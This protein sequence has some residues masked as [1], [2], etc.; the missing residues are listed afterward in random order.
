MIYSLDNENVLFVV[1][2]LMVLFFF[3]F[4]MTCLVTTW[5]KTTSNFVFFSLKFAKVGHMFYLSLHRNSNLDGQM[6]TK[7][8][9]IYI[10]IHIN[11]K[12]ESAKLWIVC[13]GAE[14]THGS[15]IPCE[16]VDSILGSFMM[17]NWLIQI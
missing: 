3:F 4:L 10:Y 1:G 8:L 11:Q 7:V 14:P 16:S 9:Y 5:L 13:W 17:L 15:G 2:D 12:E 6:A